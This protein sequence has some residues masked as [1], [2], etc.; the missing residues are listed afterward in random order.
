MVIL[1][2]TINLAGAAI[3]V[4]ILEEI[5]PDQQNYSLHMLRIPFPVVSHPIMPFKREGSIRY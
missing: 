4:G 1:T 2:N 5:Y 3:G